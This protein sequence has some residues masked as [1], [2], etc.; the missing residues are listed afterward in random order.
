M[1]SER[2]FN[3]LSSFNDSVL[4]AF[5]CILT[6]V[7][8]AEQM[9]LSKDSLTTSTGFT[10]QYSSEQELIL[11]E[12]DSKSIRWMSGS[13]QTLDRWRCVQFQKEGRTLEKSLT[14]VLQENLERCPNL[15]VWSN[16]PS[17]PERN[18]QGIAHTCWLSGR[19]WW[20]LAVRATWWEPDHPRSL[21]TP[22]QWVP[23]QVLWFLNRIGVS[24]IL[25]SW[26]E[27]CVT[28]QNIMHMTTHAHTYRY[29]YGS[30]MIRSACLRNLCT[31][32]LT[33][34]H[35]SIVWLYA[36]SIWGD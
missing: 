17:S 32:F 9:V 4:Q 6:V 14:S 3:N 18:L 34:A 8:Q 10:F 35:A 31:V 26:L 24:I 7:L 13:L 30:V 29:A 23:I 25:I 33:A 19:G 1:H 21:L 36:F 22:I 15:H 28:L 20:G 5:S 12:K 27:I 16:P 2:E 11:T